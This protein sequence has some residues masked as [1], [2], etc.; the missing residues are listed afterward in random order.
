MLDG[1]N[2][3]GL[4]VAIF[5]DDETASEFG[6]HPFQGIGLHE[7]QSMRYLL[8]NCRNV[9]EAKE[10]ILYHKHFYSFVPCQYL[11]AD[12]EGNSFVFEF[13]PL[14]NR[15][16]IIEGEGPQFISNHPLSK[17]GSLDE[18]PTDSQLS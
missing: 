9:E 5:G 11:V 17:Y 8:D 6:L 14:R 1:I 3:E 15:T 2:S 12:G 7:L 10:T 13:S 4:T 18:L 16:F